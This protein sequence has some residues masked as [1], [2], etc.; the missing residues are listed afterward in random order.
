MR[1]KSRVNYK[2]LA[3]IKLPRE[4]KRKVVSTND[5]LFPVSVLER[6]DSQVKVH[7]IGYASIHDEWRDIGELELLDLREEDREN[8]SFTSFQPHSLYKDLSI[9]IKQGLTCGRKNSPI[10]RI[11]MSFDLIQFNGGLKECGF[12]SRKFRG[13]ERFKIKHYRDLD[14]LLGQNWHYRG[15]NINGDYGYA[16]Q[17]T[18]EFYIFKSRPLIEY[19]PP[20]GS[21]S[22]QTN[23]IDTGYTLVFSFICQCGTPSTFG[24]NKEVFF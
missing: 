17:E 19:L 23:R 8:A 13:V 14:N 3:E 4:K 11:L 9:K 2:E 10:V 20:S 15:L 24:K 5:Q 1:K 12:L 18:V 21:D 7:Y 6:E 16:V 22:A